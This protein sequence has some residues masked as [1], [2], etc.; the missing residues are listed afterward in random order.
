MKKFWPILAT[1][2]CL[3]GGVSHAQVCPTLTVTGPPSGAPASWLSEGK[4]IGA[5]VELVEN[6]G[7][8]AGAQKVVVR[9]FPTFAESL[10]AVYKGEVDVIF[11]AGFS[12]ER[13]RYLDYIRPSFASQF[14]Y[15]IVRR[16]EAFDLQKFE[17]L[18]GRL[19]ASAAGET[20]GDGAFGEFVRKEL[21]LQR[22]T[23]LSKSIDMLLDNQVDFVFGFESR[24]RAAFG[25]SSRFADLSC[26]DSAFVGLGPHLPVSVDFDFAPLGQE[27][28]DRH[29][30]AVESSG[31]LVG[32]LFEFATE[33][34]NGHYP[35]EGAD[36]ALHF[37]G[38]IDVPFGRDAATIVLDGHRAVG[39]DGYRDG[40]GEVGH[41]LIDRVVDDLV[42]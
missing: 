24:F 12:E 7:Y 11:S 29:T 31:G 5:A 39:I 22:P 30:H 28:H 19:G 16:G 23:D 8:K 38:K 1:L 40:F 37:F 33:L 15:V 42:D 27:V 36:V 3:S 13:E 21:K 9:S 6:M 17:D 26:R 35:F 18:S 2:L 25:R 4:L 14:L 41:G 10:S 20:Y 34:Q 32:F